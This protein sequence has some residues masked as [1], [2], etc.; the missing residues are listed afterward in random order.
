M[1]VL[2]ATLVFYVG[3]TVM[4]VLVGYV[5]VRYHIESVVLITFMLMMICENLR[6][7]PA[8]H[9][10]V[11]IITVIEVLVTA[12]MPGFRD[13][14]H[15]AVT[16]RFENKLS[17]VSVVPE[18]IFM[19]D[20]ELSKIVQNKTVGILCLSNSYEIGG[21]T[22]WKIYSTPETPEWRKVEY[23][24]NE[25]M[26]IQ[27]ILVAPEDYIYGSGD[28]LEQL[29]SKYEKIKINKYFLYIGR[30]VVIWV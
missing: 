9:G 19:L 20:A 21:W 17:K 30:I 28:V 18:E 22:D 23:A 16:E 10:W 24:I 7:Y 12:L 1:A 8:K 2:I 13:A 11:A 3:K 5:D 27:Y 6:L 26:N 25:F 4:F 29:D 15:S 14:T